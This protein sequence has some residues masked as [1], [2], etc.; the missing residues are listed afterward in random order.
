MSKKILTKRKTNYNPNSRN[1]KFNIALKL[2]MEFYK[3]PATKLMLHLI[4]KH[5][6]TQEQL[7]EI[8]G[9]TRQAIQQK[10]LGGKE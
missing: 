1:S 2:F 9:V 6:Y 7:A 10:W 5:H 4:E 8:V 3:E